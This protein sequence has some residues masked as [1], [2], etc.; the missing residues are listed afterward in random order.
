MFDNILTPPKS[1]WKPPYWEVLG[2]Q[3]F[4]K[5]RLEVDLKLVSGQR[6]AR[7]DDLQLGKTS[8][9]GRWSKLRP[10]EE[11]GGNSENEGLTRRCRW[12]ENAD[13]SKAV[14]INRQSANHPGAGKQGGG[15]AIQARSWLAT[16]II[17]Y[18]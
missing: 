14:E 15:F 9:V 5:A 10:K 6:K 1:E 7:S 4:R 13:A 17:E 3:E 16:A 18:L 11:S 2:S 8:F 12:P